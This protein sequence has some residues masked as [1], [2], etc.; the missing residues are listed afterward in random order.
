M[1]ESLAPDRHCRRA[2]RGEECKPGTSSSEKSQ[3]GV[4]ESVS[5][6]GGRDAIAGYLLRR[7]KRCRAHVPSSMWMYTN[8]WAGGH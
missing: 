2:G 5:L 7:R 4:E 3:N 8:M 1:L 6:G